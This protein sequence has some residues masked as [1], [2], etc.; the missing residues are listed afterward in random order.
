MQKAYNNPHQAPEY[1]ETDPDVI[2]VPIKQGGVSNLAMPGPHFKSDTLIRKIPIWQVISTQGFNNCLLELSHGTS[3]TQNIDKSE[4]PDFKAMLSSSQ[5]AAIFEEGRSRSVP[6]P[7]CNG[8]RRGDIGSPTSWNSEATDFMG[9][10]GPMVHK[11][12]RDTDAPFFQQ[13]GFDFNNPRSKIPH[14]VIP[15]MADHRRMHHLEGLKRHADIAGN[16]LNAEVLMSDSLNGAA[17]SNVPLGDIL[18]IGAQNINYWST[19]VQEAVSVAGHLMNHGVFL[20]P[21]DN[22]TGL[23]AA[24]LIECDIY[25]IHAYTLMKTTLN[26]IKEVPPSLQKALQESRYELVRLGWGTKYEAHDVN[27]V[28][29]TTIEVIL[30]RAITLHRNDQSI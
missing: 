2:N 22:T 13:M 18:Y 12:L 3:I 7:T 16:S 10:V 11:Q 27:G 6:I 9:G 26:M 28:I 4:E 24:C 5:M 21:R 15:N 30:G 29:L 25:T 1:D 20:V 23:Y 14:G 19:V 8:L 17:P